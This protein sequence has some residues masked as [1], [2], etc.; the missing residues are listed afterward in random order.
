MF[1][2]DGRDVARYNR[3]IEAGAEPA[4]AIDALARGYE[5][6]LIARLTER[7]AE[8]HRSEDAQARAEAGNTHRVE[9]GADGPTNPSP[10]PL[11]S[12]AAE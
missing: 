10:S 4:E 12:H 3:L 6:E 7:R 2:S 1:S 9:P 8:L 5:G 11:M